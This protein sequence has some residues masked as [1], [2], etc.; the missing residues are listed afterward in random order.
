METWQKVVSGAACGIVGMVAL[1]VL[2]PFGAITAAG[3]LIGASLGGGVAYM[4]SEDDAPV[5]EARG[6][7]RAKAEYDLQLQAFVAT[8]QRTTDHHVAQS[9]HID[10]LLSLIG[11]GMACARARDGDYAMAMSVKEFA[12]GQGLTFLPP[13][14]LHMID[15][16][17]A[18]PPTLKSAYLRARQ[19]APGDLALFDEMVHLVESLDAPTKSAAPSTP[20]TLWRQ[21]RAA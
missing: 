9:H 7:G 20:S 12:C 10:V 4:A 11:V 14:V 16:L 3:A 2:A 17:V 15:I 8:L 21:L 5:A 19:V 1:P 18:S 13:A 6:H